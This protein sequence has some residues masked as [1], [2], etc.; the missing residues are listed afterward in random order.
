[1]SSNPY[2]LAIESFMWK[3]LKADRE[4]RVSLEKSAEL[5]DLI[6]NQLLRQY[7]PDTQS[8]LGE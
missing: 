5:Y 1:M 7:R 4:G 8:H 2:E 3:A 6:F